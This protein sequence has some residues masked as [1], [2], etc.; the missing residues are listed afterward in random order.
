MPFHKYTA[1]ASAPWWE[2]IDP[3][4][5]HYGRALALSQFVRSIYRGPSLMMSVRKIAYRERCVKHWR[6]Y[7]AH[8]APPPED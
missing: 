8:G 3:S 6:Y 7:L 4:H 5:P 1:T 2:G